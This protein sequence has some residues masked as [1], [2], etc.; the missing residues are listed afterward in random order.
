MPKP[1]LQIG[2]AIKYGQW[3]PSQSHKSGIL[4]HLSLFY[5]TSC[6][7]LEG[8]HGKHARQTTSQHLGHKVSKEI[9]KTHYLNL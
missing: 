4:G 5:N 6:H 8:F 7:K 9:S 1:L 3:T 2:N